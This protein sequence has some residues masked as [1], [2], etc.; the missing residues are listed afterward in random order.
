MGLLKLHCFFYCYSNI[1]YWCST[2]EERLWFNSDAFLC[3][4][5]KLTVVLISLLFFFFFCYD[6]T[7]S[8]HLGR[9]NWENIF[10]RL[11]A[12]QVYGLWV[13]SWL[14]VSRPRPRPEWAAPYLSRGPWEVEESKLSEQTLQEKPVSIPPWLL[15]PVLPEFRPWLPAVMNYELSAEINPS[16][17]IFLCFITATAK[18][19]RTAGLSKRARPQ[20]AASGDAW[21]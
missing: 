6:D 3:Q 4:V 15:L 8:R 5:D 19:T 21:S 20:H 12:R 13:F 1:R 11:T 18:R 10:I 17:P 9:G 16:F 7:N 2:T 14:M